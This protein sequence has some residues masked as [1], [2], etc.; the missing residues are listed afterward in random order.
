MTR[1]NLK[2]W[3]MQV[4]EGSLKCLVSIIQQDEYF[5]K[6]LRFVPRDTTPIAFVYEMQGDLNRLVMTLTNM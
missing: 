5:M 3:L 6:H 1:L 2:K 4:S